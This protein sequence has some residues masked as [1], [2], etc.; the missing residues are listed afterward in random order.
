MALSKEQ[1]GNKIV[2]ITSRES[3][4]NRPHLSITVTQPSPNSGEEHP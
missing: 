1:G 3:D 4:T 2:R